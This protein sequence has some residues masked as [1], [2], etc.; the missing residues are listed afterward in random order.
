[1]LIS[2]NDIHPF[3]NLS[4]IVD[5]DQGANQLKFAIDKANQAISQLQER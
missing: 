1:M 3:H 5:L 2:T 4:I